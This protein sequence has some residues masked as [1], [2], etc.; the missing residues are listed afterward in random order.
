MKYLF[1]LIFLFLA[2]MAHCTDLTVTWDS[3]TDQA[4]IDG[5]YLYVCTSSPC[6]AIVANRS[7]TITTKTLTSYTLTGQTVGQKYAVMTAFKGTVES[8]KSNEGSGVIR[9]LPMSGIIITIK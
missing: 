1:T 7:A 8:L 3:Y 5:Y 2:S 4:N 6:E 9:P